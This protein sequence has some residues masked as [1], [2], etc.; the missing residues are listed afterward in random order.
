MA[1]EQFPNHPAPQDEDW[2][3]WA[4]LANDITFALG[5]AGVRVL[6]SK[7]NK[8]AEALWNAGYRPAEERIQFQIERQKQAFDGKRI[9]PL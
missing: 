2:K 3:A 5:E 4:T 8:I 1:D 9:A 6:F 7:R